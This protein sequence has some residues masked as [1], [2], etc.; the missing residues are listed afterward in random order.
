MFA[1]SHNMTSSLE[2]WT[3][4]WVALCEAF[5]KPVQLRSP[6]EDTLTDLR[7]LEQPSFSISTKCCRGVGNVDRV[8]AQV[9]D[10]LCLRKQLRAWQWRIAR[11]CW[12]REFQ[13]ARTIRQLIIPVHFKPLFKSQTAK[14]PVL[15]NMQINIAKSLIHPFT[16]AHSDIVHLLI[17]VEHMHC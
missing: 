8:Q 10:C 9:S 5:N 15:T 11:Q 7:A 17:A 4:S 14:S 16:V 6:V 2:S 13:N 3:S 1:T 12:A